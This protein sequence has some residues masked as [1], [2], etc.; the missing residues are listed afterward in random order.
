[1]TPHSP[2]QL[3]K[4]GRGVAIQ[5]WISAISDVR[6]ERLA[7]HGVTVPTPNHVHLILVPDREEP[8]GPRAP[9]KASRGRFGV[10]SWWAFDREHE[11]NDGERRSGGETRMTQ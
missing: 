4:S 6:Q 3:Q 8:L 1:M 10:G 7:R 2:D 11:Q 5:L 9:G